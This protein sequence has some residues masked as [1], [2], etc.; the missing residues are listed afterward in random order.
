MLTISKR[1]APHHPVI[2]RNNPTGLEM[3]LTEVSSHVLKIALYD[4]TLRYF[5]CG[6]FY[7]NQVY[8]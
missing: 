7:H 6:A 2:Q 5:K 1:F 3:Y 4:R 8:F